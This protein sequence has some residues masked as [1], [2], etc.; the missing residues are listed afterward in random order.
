[1]RARRQ[2]NYDLGRQPL[3]RGPRQPLLQRP[4]VRAV[5]AGRLL[6][7]KLLLAGVAALFLATGAAHADQAALDVCDQRFKAGELQPGDEI[8]ACYAKATNNRC[9][10]DLDGSR[11][12]VCLDWVESHP[13]MKPAA[14]PKPSWVINCRK[15]Q[16]EYNGDEETVR[17]LTLKDIR[18]IEKL[19]PYLKKCE[20]FWECVSRRGTKWPDGHAWV[21][22]PAGSK[23]GAEQ[24][25]GSALVYPPAKRPKHCY[26][27]RGPD[28]TPLNT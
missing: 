7:K 6:M 3:H 19:T 22:P 14:E 16:I 4:A 5:A 28:G 12:Q 1:M 11:A 24:P 8:G 25:D 15:T 20:A 17:A 9:D 13:K 18:E 2:H 27:P 10:G 23:L 21:Y 26:P